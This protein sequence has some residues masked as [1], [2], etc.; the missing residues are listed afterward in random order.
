MSGFEIQNATQIKTKQ[1]LRKKINKLKNLIRKRTNKKR[2]IN[3]IIKFVI[4]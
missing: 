1:H 4:K 2:K 3:K